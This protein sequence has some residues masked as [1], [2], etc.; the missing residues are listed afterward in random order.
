MELREDIGSALK[1]TQ[2]PEGV[3]SGLWLSRGLTGGSQ[4]VWGTEASTNWIVRL[5]GRGTLLGPP[6]TLSLYSLFW[7]L[8]CLCLFGV[9]HY[10][11]CG[12]L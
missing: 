12:D 8:L 1:E 4:A 10:P 11:S 9:T 3:F 7:A 2:S 6:P 5:H